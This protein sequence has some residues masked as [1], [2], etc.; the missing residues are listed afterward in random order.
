MMAECIPGGDGEFNGWLDDFV[1]YAGANWGKIGLADTRTRVAS[2][3]S[4]S[5]LVPPR[6]VGGRVPCPRGVEPIHVAAV[7]RGNGCF[8]CGRF[9]MCNDFRR[10]RES[11][12]NPALPHV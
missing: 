4:K 1:T 7:K 5:P 11:P 8:P 6:P 10:C 9:C 2:L 3:S 12:L